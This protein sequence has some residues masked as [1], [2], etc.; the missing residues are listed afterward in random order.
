MNSDTLSS[1]IMI[2]GQDLFAMKLYWVAIS[3]LWLYEYCLTF[4]DEI[5]YAWKG[6]KTFVCGI[7]SY[8]KPRY[9]EQIVLEPLSVSNVHW[10]HNV[11]LKK[12]LISQPL[13]AYFLPGFG[14]KHYGFM[15]TL[16]TMLLTC[17]CEIFLTLRV[18]ALSKCHRSVLVLSGLI[19]VWQWGIAVYAMSQSSQGT[20]Q[21][22]LLLT[23]PSASH[24]VALPATDPYHICIFIS[25]LT[26]TSWV[27]AF[28]CLSL[29]F[30]ALVFIAILWMTFRMMAKQ[31]YQ[32]VHILEVIQRDGIF[33]FFVLFSSNL[34][35]LLLLLHARASLKFIHNQ[36][37]MIV[38]SIMINRITLN[39]KKASE[40]GR[41][42][43]YTWSMRTFEQQYDFNLRHSHYLDDSY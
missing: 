31:N 34:L 25:T 42:P 1:A 24:F 26:V 8:Y 15:E 33:Y 3:A 6:D 29:A 12:R 7:Y 5:E 36:P 30:D 39:L 19:I 4:H 28:L 18:Y 40:R 17:L 23:G 37:A 43:T 32:F 2:L 13:E 21:I 22:S 9:T 38:S 35:W 10:H 41:Q 11:L 20:D 27:E 14:L 16:E